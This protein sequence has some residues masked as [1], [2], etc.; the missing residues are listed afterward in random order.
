MKYFVRIL[1]VGFALS[2][3]V[4]LTG[5]PFSTKKEK[6]VKPVEK[7]YEARTSPENLLHNLKEAYIRREHDRYVELF[8]RTCYQFEFSDEDIRDGVPSEFL[9]YEEEVDIHDRMF[10]SELL[11]QLSLE[12][13]VGA[14]EYDDT[15]TTD[16]ENPVYRIVVTN[17]VLELRG[18]HPERPEDPAMTWQLING[19]QKF[20]FHQRGPDGQEGTDID[21]GDPLWSIVKWKETSVSGGKK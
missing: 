9:T 4:M 19:E 10:H 21:T 17:V 3:V 13:T 6:E 20:W 7:I 5:C 12:Y 8:D 16:P 18:R 15:E 11:D 14:K 1:T 2:L